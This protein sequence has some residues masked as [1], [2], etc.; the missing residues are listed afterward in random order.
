VTQNLHGLLIVQ[1]CQEINC[2]LQVAASGKTIL[3]K[4]VEEVGMLEPGEPA[5]K[6]AAAPQTRVNQYL[7]K[8]G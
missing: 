3:L 2:E 6:R 1:L 8:S 7:G 5:A 4:E